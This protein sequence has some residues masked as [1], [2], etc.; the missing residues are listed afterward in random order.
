LATS[1][2]PASFETRNGV[3]NTAANVDAVVIIMDNAKSP[4]AIKVTYIS[5]NKNRRK[6]VCII[7]ETMQVG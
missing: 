1:K 7:I 2:L 5:E 4:L 6:Y 3:I